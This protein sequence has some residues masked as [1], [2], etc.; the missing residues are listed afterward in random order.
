MAILFGQVLCKRRKKKT[1]AVMT[2]LK[3][4]TNKVSVNE[5]CISESSLGH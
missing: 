5:I 3:K 1:I 4:D 2:V